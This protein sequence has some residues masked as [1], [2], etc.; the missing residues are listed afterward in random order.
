VTPEAARRLLASL[1][2][3]PVSGAGGLE[4]LRDASADPPRLVDAELRESRTLDARRIPEGPAATV[5]AFLDGRQASEVV[6]H[7][8]LVPLVFGHVG[9]VIRV[10]H[11]RTLSTWRARQS[12][13]IYLPRPSI[14]PAV[15]AHCASATNVVDTSH[16]AA[17]GP[18]HPM[19]WADRAYHQVQAA[20]ESLE[21]ALARDWVAAESGLLY[22]DGGIGKDDQVATAPHVVGV[23]K[24]H[25]TLYVAGDA[26][27]VLAS[28]RA[29]DRTT[30]FAITSPRRTTVL[31]WYLRLRDPEGR[32]PMFGLVRL[33]VALRDDAP[34][35]LTAH[36]DAVS[37][38]VLAERA[39]VALPDRRWAV[40]SYGVRDCEEYLRAVMA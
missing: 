9:A 13:A 11:D 15:W 27:G 37:R 31:S 20:R 23:I 3:R 28:L 36:L 25:R 14:D 17:D 34:G 10:R 32:E 29:G 35:A 30:A 12:T 40:M 2:A 4:L 19:A 6:A 7:A 1:G 22:V 33:E 38:G 26:V 21:H 18:Q 8:G 24:S 5:A 39:P 16:D